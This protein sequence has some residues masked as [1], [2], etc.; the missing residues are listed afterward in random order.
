MR[1]YAQIRPRFWTQGTGKLLRGDHEA[2]ELALYLVSAPTSNLIGL[3]YLPIVVIAHELGSSL[4]GA[5]EALQRVCDTG[6]ARYDDSSEYVWVVNMAREQVGDDVKKT[7][8]RIAGVKNE[9]RK[10]DKCPFF[11]DFM[12]HYSD[13]FGLQKPPPSNRPTRSP[14]EAPSEPLEGARESGTGTGTG[15]GER[16]RA[17]EADKPLVEFAD[18]D[19]P[20]DLPANDHDAQ[21]DAERLVRRE[22]SRR[23]EAAQKDLW[24]QPNDP[25][26]TTL[27]TWLSRKPAAERAA[28]LAKTLDTF[29]ADPWARAN[30]FP[31]NHLGRYAKKYF[32]PRD[33]PRAPA[34]ASPA[35]AEYERRNPSIPISQASHK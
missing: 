27:A 15:T 18:D 7:D 23:Y 31:V 35:D 4:E 24:T 30:H 20:R 19:L 28:A 29:F 9:L 25:G 8:N 34:R 22:F 2:R 10:H 13:L 11:A 17:R 6:F 21:A 1:D 33:M 32:E 14:S 5:R 16:E 26:V 12:R 3:Y